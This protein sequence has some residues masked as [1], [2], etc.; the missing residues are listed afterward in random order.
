MR[1]I[2]DLMLDFA[3][4]QYLTQNKNIIS[5]LQHYLVHGN[6][7]LKKCV[8]W[9]LTNILCNGQAELESVLKSGIFSNVTIAARS[10]TLEIRKEAF[11]V[12]S[13]LFN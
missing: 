13:S 3:Y 9:I 6:E 8:L 2:G 4:C 7:D 11:W 12:I 5:Y 1:L 10:K